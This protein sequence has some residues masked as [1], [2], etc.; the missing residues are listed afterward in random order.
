VSVRR[1]ALTSPNKRCFGAALFASLT[2]VKATLSYSKPSSARTG[3]LRA[4]RS[5]RWCVLRKTGT[6]KSF[7]RVGDACDFSPGASEDRAFR[8]YF[9]GHH[10]SERIY[11]DAAGIRWAN[12]VPAR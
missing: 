10:R 5:R 9:A 8:R 6:T 4:P 3:N 7:S 11:V 12:R 1:V 2:L